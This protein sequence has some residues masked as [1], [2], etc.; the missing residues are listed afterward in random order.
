MG[1]PW[2]RR[3]VDLVAVTLDR[4]GPCIFRRSNPACFSYAARWATPA[5]CRLCR[6][7]NGG[8]RPLD[9]AVAGAMR[10]VFD[11]P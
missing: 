2:T 5:L 11:Y 6:D 7:D 1:A 10:H 4:V 9:G 3:L 8:S